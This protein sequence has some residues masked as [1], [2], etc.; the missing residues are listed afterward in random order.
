MKAIQ[1]KYVAVTGLLVLGLANQSFAADATE[2]ARTAEVIEAAAVMVDLQS[3]VVQSRLNAVNDLPGGDVDLDAVEERDKQSAEV[4]AA[5]AAGNEAVAA[6]NL[7]NENGD[8]EAFDA[9]KADLAEALVQ[10]RNALLGILPATAAAADP[11]DDSEQDLDPPNIYDDPWESQG[12]RAYYQ[13]LFV[14]FNEA[15]SY[16][17]GTDTDATQE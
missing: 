17:Q 16:D 4:D 6:M 5:V 14:V 1:L 10:A 2:A 13:S 11:G 9:A 3:L 12:I 15:S 7:A 8:A